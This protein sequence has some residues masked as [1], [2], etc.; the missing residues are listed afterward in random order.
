[1][2]KIAKFTRKHAHKLFIPL[3]TTLESLHRY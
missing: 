3:G 2:P 1:M